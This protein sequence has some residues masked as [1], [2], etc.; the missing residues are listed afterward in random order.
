MIDHC[1]VTHMTPLGS[2]GIHGL[3]L[4]RAGKKLISLGRY[5]L[6]LMLKVAC[7]LPIAVPARFVSA[8]VQ[9]DKA[10]GERL[11]KSTFFGRKHYWASLKTSGASIIGP[12]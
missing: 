5:F 10:I 6:D 8:D 2:G 1:L 7:L 4:A 9:L 3:L 12:L 11:S